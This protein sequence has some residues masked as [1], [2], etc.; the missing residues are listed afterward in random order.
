[1]FTAD[2]ASARLAKE[3]GK[4]DIIGAV[5][6]DTSKPESISAAVHNLVKG[7]EGKLDTLINNAAVSMPPCHAAWHFRHWR[8]CHKRPD[9]WLCT[10]N[11]SCS[12]AVR[13]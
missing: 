5:A 11:E 2:D 12:Y 8:P 13:T 1:M 10:T 7:F 6:L 9:S 3:T 4:P